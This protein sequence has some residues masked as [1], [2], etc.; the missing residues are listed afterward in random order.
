[1]TDEI[2]KKITAWLESPADSRNIE[3]G[4]LLLLKVNRNKIFYR[5]CVMNPE[6]ME[7]RLVY[8]LEKLVNRKIVQ[9]THKEV[10]EMAKKVQKIAQKHFTYQQ[11]NPASEFQAGKRGDHDSLPLDIQALYVEN[12]SLV[13]RMR[14]VHVQLRII[15]NRPG[16][17][18]DSDRY[19]YLKELIEL[20]TQL[21]K[22]WELYD[23]YDAN[24]PD[25]IP[26]IDARE[27]SKRA[28]AYIN[29][30]KKR[31]GTNPTAELKEKLA[32]AYAKVI[33][34]TEKMTA[35]LKELGIIE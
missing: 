17:C 15:T 25:I 2:L 18:P 26:S 9:V 34:P 1:M 29:L 3:Q 35:E 28:V 13:Q 27:A 24:S 30:N 11:D 32:E 23:N 20:D 14:D 21:H 31:Y 22:N 5:N 8:E 19:P 4:A 16:F 10:E 12:K 6:K 33:N 7:K